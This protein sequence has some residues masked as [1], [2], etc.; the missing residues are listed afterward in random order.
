[1]KEKIVNQ[2]FA[3]LKNIFQK[4]DYL[5]KIEFFRGPDD[6]NNKNFDKKIHFPQENRIFEKNSSE[7]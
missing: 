4:Y 6:R 3:F 2:K 7:K 5:V 1:V